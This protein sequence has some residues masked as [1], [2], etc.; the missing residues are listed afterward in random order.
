MRYVVLF[1]LATSLLALTGC[2]SM[3]TED[4]GRGVALGGIGSGHGGI[5]ALGAVV[6]LAGQAAPRPKEGTPEF[7]RDKLKFYGQ[8]LPL[9]LMFEFREQVTLGMTDQQISDAA[10]KRCAGINEEITSKGS[11]TLQRNVLKNLMT[12]KYLPSE[13]SI[14][15]KTSKDPFAGIFGSTCEQKLAGSGKVHLKK[16]EE[17][18]ANKVTTSAS[19]SS[20]KK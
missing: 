19:L 16:L 9:V 7:E 8:V 14:E 11:I 18:Q 5:A 20:D 2:A 15:Y 17:R 12:E 6:E 3:S 13:D 4:V 1:V 10:V